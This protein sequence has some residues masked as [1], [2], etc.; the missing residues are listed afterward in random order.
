MRSKAQDTF[1]EDLKKKTNIEI[2]DANLAKVVVEAGP[3]GSTP[4]GG[5][6]LPG[7]PSGA[8]GAP[9]PNTP[10]A[11]RVQPAGSP[12]TPNHP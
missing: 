9:P 3:A 7:M 1:V 5:V 4:S 12:P 11:S 6:A 2:N 10:A 8:V